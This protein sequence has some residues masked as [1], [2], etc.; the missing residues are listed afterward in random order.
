MSF[1][2]WSLSLP[3]MR[4]TA[5]SR[6]KGI[7]TQFS[8]GQLILYAVS[9][10]ILT[11]P[12]TSASKSTVKHDLLSLFRYSLLLK[13]P[14][15]LSEV[16]DDPPSAFLTCL[17]QFMR[18]A[19]PSSFMPMQRISAKELSLSSLTSSWIACRTKFLKSDPSDHASYRTLS[20]S[21]SQRGFSRWPT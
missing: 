14:F 2:N 16:V 10:N 3:L 1:A 5:I 18:G 19:F 8:A 15:R 4:L 12:G 13:P 7:V 21:L 11:H 17:T 6:V 20:R 9:I